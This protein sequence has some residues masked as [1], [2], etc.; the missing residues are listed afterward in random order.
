[1]LTNDEHLIMMQL[2]Q[3]LNVNIHDD[4]A[5]KHALEMNQTLMQQLM[6]LDAN[7]LTMEEQLLAQ[8]VL[9][10]YQYLLA[11]IDIR[12]RELQTKISATKQGKSTATAYMRYTTEATFVNRDL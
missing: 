4:D 12:K 8:E 3:N 10:K 1:M 11:A 7:S 9:N 5:I 2:N 6:Q